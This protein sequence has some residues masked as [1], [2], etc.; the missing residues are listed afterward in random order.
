M[1]TCKLCGA[2]GD[3]RAWQGAEK[4]FGTGEVF[5]Y[6]ECPKCETLQIDEFPKDMSSHYPSSYYSYNKPPITHAPSGTTPKTP[7]VLDVGCGG[8]AYLCNLASQ[9]FVNLAGCDPF[10]DR[11]Y[12]YENGVEIKKCSIHEMDGE[13]DMIHLSHVFE[14]M[15]D[16]D[17]VFRTF[18]RLLRRQNING[19]TPYIEIHIPVYPNIAFDKFGVDWY[20]LDA[21]RHFFIHSVKS[22]AALA[23][24]HGFKIY[25]TTYNSTNYLQFTVSLCYQ[26]GIPF[27]DYHKSMETDERCQAI[28]ASIPMYQDLVRQAAQKGYSDE[29]RFQIVRK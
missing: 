1:K 20:Q 25:D 23:D 14:H 28:K 17:D 8:G 6:F 12:V 29:A 2:N 22:M 19:I 5:I 9:G 7:H 16:P 24:K 11:D 15:P 10:I 21:P 26:M 4:F 27:V 18:D 3:F 13:Y